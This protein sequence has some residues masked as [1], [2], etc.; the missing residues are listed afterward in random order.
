M[1]KN[2]YRVILVLLV[3]SVVIGTPAVKVEP[4][5]AATTISSIYYTP[6]EL[7]ALRALKTSPSHSAVWNN[8]K[9]W[10]DAHINDPPTP[11]AAPVTN[12]WYNW[13]QYADNI[14][15]YVETFTF[16]YAMTDNTA[17]A[18]AAVKWM[19][20]VAGWSRWGP[21][22]SQ[23]YGWSRSRMIRAFAMGYSELKGYVNASQNTAI[24][25]PLVRELDLLRD[26]IYKSLGAPS[27][28][29]DYANH[30]GTLA[31]A[32]GIGALALGSSQPHYTDWINTAVLCT[33]EYLSRAGQEGG[34]Y[35]GPAYTSDPVSFLIPWMDAYRRAGGTNYFAG[36]NFLANHAYY[37][38]YLNYEIEGKQAWIA[39]EDSEVVLGQ[40]PMH[41]YDNPLDHFMYLLAKEYNNGYAE[42]YADLHC[43]Q[44]LVQSY[45]WRSSTVTAQDIAT[46]PKTRTFTSNDI[47]VVVMRGDWTDTGLVAVFKSGKSRGHAHPGQN[48]FTIY[49]NGHL[50]TGDRGYIWGAE[51]DTWNQNSLLVNAS[52][53]I[54]ST[55]YYSYGGQMQ[56]PGDYDNPYYYPAGSVLGEIEQTDIGQYFRYV[57]GDAAAVYNGASSD[58]WDGESETWTGSQGGTVNIN[59][60]TYGS[61]PPQTHVAGSLDKFL[62]HFVYVADPSYFVIY[63]DVAAPAAS[64]FEYV[65]NGKTMSLAGNV[66]TVDTDKM[67]SVILEPATIQSNITHYTVNHGWIQHDYNV[68]RFSANTNSTAAHFLTV[69][70]PGSTA[71]PVAKVDQN[72]VQGVIVT[73]SRGC[74]LVLFSKNGAPVNEYIELGGNY[75]S[76]DGNPYTFNGTR[77]Q[78]NFTT[79]QVMRLAT[80]TTPPVLASIG[81]KSVKEGQIL[82]FAIS[83]NSSVGRRLIYSASNLPDGATFNPETKTFSWTTP[84]GE[85]GTYSIHFEVS[86][87]LLTD[88]ENITITVESGSS[89]WHIW[90]WIVAVLIA[91]G[92]GVPIAI[93]TNRRQRR[94]PPKS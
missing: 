19:V 39:V 30:W 40:H 6:A 48:S 66:I 41:P 94:Q 91:A 49:N 46:L 70:F 2:I 67:K 52:F 59:A 5:R 74:D 36:N 7:D 64:K 79:Y 55:R 26:Y 24:Q 58:G 90:R 25:T 51:A 81:N 15:R 13:V 73:T 45:V 18:D 35:E 8:I 75:Q 72:N 17:Y 23:D 86:D 56:E 43:Q 42:R 53:V 61:G 87:G 21:D 9:T 12:D 69:N 31:S 27:N 22:M 63:D 88:S 85:A 93:I 47:G 14:R 84:R 78:A 57:R 71:L 50:V 65:M 11:S 89:P 29:T 32:V 3:L 34:Y 83:G 10:A 82:Q 16:M 28:L 33:N 62:R 80:N 20:S 54:N 76:A 38:I 68:L 37:Y 77:V 44:D 1:N 60:V 92:V 4:V